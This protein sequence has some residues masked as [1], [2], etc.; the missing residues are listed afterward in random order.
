MRRSLTPRRPAPRRPALRDRLAALAP[1]SRGA[2][3]IVTAM[4]FFVSM[5]AIAK[6]LAEELPT[7]QVVWARYL[8]QTLIVLALFAHR[9]R[10]LLRT[11]APG[12]QALR[13]VLLFSATSL[14][15]Y[16]LSFLP[17][18]EAAALM[19][20]APL[21][22]TLLAALVLGER[23]GPR[24]WAGVAAGFAGALIIIRPGLGV[25]EP[26]ALLLLLAAVCIASYQ[27][28][29]RMMGQADSIWTTMLY[30]TLFGAVVSS[31]VLPFVWETPPLALVPGLV[32]IGAIGFVGHTLLVWSLGQAP[33]SV[34]AP[35]NYAQ[36][37]WAILIGYLVFGDW[38]D[39]ATLIGGAV[40]V[41]AGLY[42]WHRERVRGVRPA[43]PP[44]GG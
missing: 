27:I 12:L 9:F 44:P 2:L 7:M 26:A 32:A 35:F 24:R 42:V 4:F 39:A 8:G 22:I 19:E 20:T 17:L 36:L 14:F 15:F 23:V 37:L 31:A 6:H 34:L 38:P 21:M 33:A 3:G 16:A 1:E 30:T 43:P 25:F 11:R 28:A 29:T 10:A 13:S 5:D 18:A 41:C 40:I